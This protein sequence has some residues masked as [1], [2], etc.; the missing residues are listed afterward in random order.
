MIIIIVYNYSQIYFMLH[1]I[2]FVSYIIPLFG[3]WKRT[4]MYCARDVAQIEVGRFKIR[5]FKQGKFWS[6]S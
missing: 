5:I 1:D 4:V 3:L 2:R 6:A